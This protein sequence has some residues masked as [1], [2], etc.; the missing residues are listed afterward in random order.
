MPRGDLPPA[1]ESP[2]ASR[3]DSVFWPALTLCPVPRLRGRQESHFDKGSGRQESHFDTQIGFPRTSPRPDFCNFLLPDGRMLWFNQHR[4]NVHTIYLFLFPAV[5]L[6]LGLVT[7]WPS[8]LL[9]PERP[10]G[11]WRRCW[12]RVSPGG[13]AA[14]QRHCKPLDAVD[15]ELPEAP[16]QHGLCFPVP[17]PRWAPRSGP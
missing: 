9:C 13:L 7:R 10:R 1:W 11:P 5:A 2:G 3:T 16:G 8:G 15:R 6:A 4:D 12:E 17:G 14:H